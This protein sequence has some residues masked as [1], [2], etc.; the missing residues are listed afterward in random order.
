MFYS[1]LAALLSGNNTDPTQLLLK[2]V[3]LGMDDTARGRSPLHRKAGYYLPLPSAIRSS[4][5]NINDCR[6][7]R[8]LLTHFLD[9]H[10]AR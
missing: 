3:V 2:Q 9:D 7:L 6:R 1:S 5:R 10:K 4:K 8:T